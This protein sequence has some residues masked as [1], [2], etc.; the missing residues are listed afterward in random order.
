M[1]KTDLFKRTALGLI[2][3]A[4]LFFSSVPAFAADGVPNVNA[5]GSISI[6][7]T[8]PTTKKAVTSGKFTLYQAAE[9]KVTDTGLYYA[10]VNGFGS[11][12]ATLTGKD[13]ENNAGLAAAL[14]KKISSSYAGVT[15]AVGTDGTV[16]FSDLPLGVY[17]VVQSELSSSYNKVSSFVVTIPQ[18]EENGFVYDVDASP[19]MQ[20]LTTPTPTPGVTV[21]PTPGGTTTTTLPQ[22]GQLF[23]PIPILAI[24]GIL[25]FTVGWTLKNK[26][27]KEK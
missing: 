5:K 19:K 8:D 12:G 3:A 9:V 7:L 20:T 21:T 4:A 1:K 11:D 23:W 18:T 6:T 27:S 24:A 2:A 14:E 22:T 13:V 15:A 25:L 16:K 26:N 17:L 10:Y